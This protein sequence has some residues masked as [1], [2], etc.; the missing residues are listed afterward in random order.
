M[1]P[2]FTVKA[3]LTLRFKRRC[4][5]RLTATTVIVVFVTL[6]VLQAASLRIPLAGY[7]ANVTVSYE[8]VYVWVNVSGLITPPYQHLVGSSGV[9]NA[10]LVVNK[11]SIPL[12]V[13][14]VEGVYIVSYEGGVLFDQGSIENTSLATGV[15]LNTGLAGY[16][17]FKPLIVESAGPGRWLLTFYSP[18]LLNVTAEISILPVNPAVNVSNRGGLAYTVII[19]V[20]GLNATERYSIQVKPYSTETLRVDSTGIPVVT[21][22][23]ASW[24]PLT[25]TVE[26]GRLT[27]DL[28]G[29]TVL[30]AVAE[31]LVAVLA[32]ARL[33]TVRDSSSKK[34]RR[35]RK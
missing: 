22:Q 3:Q 23:F 18:Y 33:C 32:A 10:S 17:P 8:R 6:L 14:V 1:S 25:L 13:E 19:D 7:N 30:I 2:G 26:D 9:L 21:G 15:V 5:K 11:T 34:A 28:S 12:N 29:N 4:L 31:I 27:I 35:K 20:Y 24:G 16:S